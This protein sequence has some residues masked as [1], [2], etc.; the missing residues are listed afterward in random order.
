MMMQVDLP[1]EPFDAYRSLRAL[2]PAF[3]FEIP[4]SDLQ[5]YIV[6]GFISR[7]YVLHGRFKGFGHSRIMRSSEDLAVENFLRDPIPKDDP[8]PLYKGDAIGCK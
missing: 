3:A 5:S 4:E 7:R 8:D 6:N 2:L 1:F